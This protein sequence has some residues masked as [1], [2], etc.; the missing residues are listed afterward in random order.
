MHL[1]S[2]ML[3]PK[4]SRMQNL[5]LVV[6]NGQK[7]F[8][9]HILIQLSLSSLMQCTIV[10]QHFQNILGICLNKDKEQSGSTINVYFTDPRWDTQTEVEKKDSKRLLGWLRMPL[11]LEINMMEGHNSWLKKFSGL[12]LM[13]LQL[14]S[15]EL[16]CQTLPSDECK[17]MHQVD[18]AQSLLHWVCHPIPY[19]YHH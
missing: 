15:D 9:F 8:I 2:M 1:F 10:N 18:Y 17:V 14:A 4:Q 12:H 7:C 5:L 19:Q 13:V 6:S 3:R 16:K 11:N